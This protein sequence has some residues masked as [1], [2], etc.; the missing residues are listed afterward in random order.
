[1]LE[2]FLDFAD[3][4]GNVVEDYI[5]ARIIVIVTITIPIVLLVEWVQN[6]N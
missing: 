1:M 6:A 3:T 5:L 4:V 2:R